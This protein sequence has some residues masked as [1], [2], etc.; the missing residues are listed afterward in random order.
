MPLVRFASG[1]ETILHTLRDCQLTRSICDLFI[2]SQAKLSFISLNLFDW[3]SSNL[4]VNA[5]WNHVDLYWRHLFRHSDLEILEAARLSDLQWS[6]LVGAGNNSV[7]WTWAKTFRDNQAKT[8]RRN[9]FQNRKHR[10]T[11]PTSKSVKL[12]IDRAA[13]PPSIKVTSGGALR[14]EDGTWLF[15]YPRNIS[16]WP[17]FQAP[18]FA[19]FIGS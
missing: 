17:I 3:L 12:N 14:D 6:N 1:E 8:L 2:P 10:W 7:T 15:G 9:I 18:F 11:P 19:G 5:G 13:A 4:S 16:R